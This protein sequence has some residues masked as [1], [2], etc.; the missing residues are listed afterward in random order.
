[1]AQLDNGIG[2][3][4]NR[5]LGTVF[6]AVYVL[7]GL[8]GFAITSGVGFASTEGK[9]L[10]GIFE[11]NPLHNIVHLAIGVA[12]I[13][14][15]RQSDLVSRA[16][17]GAVGGTYALVGVLGLFLLGN[18]ANILALNAADNGLHFASAIALLGVSL[19]GRSGATVAGSTRNTTRV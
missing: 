9:D 3:S 5:V 13:V 14:A 17:N 19:V 11:V 16:A 10:L 2:S 1:M 7:V 4:A 12:L 8:L 6:G 15:A 18:D